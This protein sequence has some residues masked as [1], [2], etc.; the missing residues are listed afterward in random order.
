MVLTSVQRLM[1]L[2]HKEMVERTILNVL[3]PKS[4][5]ERLSVGSLFRCNLKTPDCSTLQFCKSLK[6]CAIRP[7]LL[8]DDSAVRSLIADSCVGE[9]GLR[10]VP[11]ETP[12]D[13]R[14]YWNGE[15][16]PPIKNSIFVGHLELP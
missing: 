3:V 15:V 5:C 12:L 14:S 10:T 6:K 13:S 1:I 7:I 9:S 8:A 11:I 2:V 16:V 4:L